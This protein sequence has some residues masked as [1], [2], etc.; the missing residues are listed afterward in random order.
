LICIAAALTCV[1]AA[2][3]CIA[4]AFSLEARRQL[5]SAATI[6]LTGSL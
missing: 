4:A 1:L 2:L 6:R 3:T 5:P